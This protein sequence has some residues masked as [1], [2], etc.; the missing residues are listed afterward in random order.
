MTGQESTK[1]LVA[2]ALAVVGIILLVYTAWARRGGSAT[3][4]AW[5]GTFFGSRPVDERMTVLGAPALGVMSLCLS[6]SLLPVVGTYLALLA[7]PLAAVAFVLFFVAQMQFIPLPNAIYPRW[8][9]ALRAR[10]RET[11]QA[12]RA[13]LRRR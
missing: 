9:R 2:V 7:L 4:R 11:E 5:M 8:S 1:L 12:V 13:S 6:A 10:R 3:A